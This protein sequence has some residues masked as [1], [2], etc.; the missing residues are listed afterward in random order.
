MKSE[1]EN[2]KMKVSACSPIKMDVVR[3]LTLVF[4]T[5]MKNKYATVTGSQITRLCNAYA[6]FSLPTQLRVLQLTKGKEEG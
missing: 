2:R 1:S 4:H 3:N 6:P 5:S